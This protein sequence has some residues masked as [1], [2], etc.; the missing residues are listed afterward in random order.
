MKNYNNGCAALY[1]WSVDG[2]GEELIH[3]NVVSGSLTSGNVIRQ[4]ASDSLTFK[5]VENN[6]VKYCYYDG[7]EAKVIS[8]GVKSWV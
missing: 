2:D 8:E 3:A 1:K 7:K 4:F 6:V 5:V